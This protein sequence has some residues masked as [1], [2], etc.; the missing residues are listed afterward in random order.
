MTVE[1]TTSR[2]GI[3]SVAAVWILMVIGAILVGIFAEPKH[4]I[5]LLP[6]VLGA[7]ILITFCVQLALDRKD[8]LVNRVMASLGG[9]VVILAIFTAIFAIV[10]ALR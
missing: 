6:V 5:A 3:R 7:G 2:R 1:Q 9:S 4:E 8:G 10:A